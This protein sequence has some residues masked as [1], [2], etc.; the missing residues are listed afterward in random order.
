MVINRAI[1]GR[2]PKEYYQDHKVKL[3]LRSKQYHQDNKV[4][5]NLWMKQYKQTNREQISVQRKQHYQTN[6]EK[7]SLKDKQYYQEN[8][9]KIK[10]QRSKSV[11]C[12]HCSRTVQRG[13]IAR[14]Q[15]STVC[16]SHQ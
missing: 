16:K 14:H 15:K 3:N 12:P 8:K 9:E 10:E 11:T 6:K 7:M 4:K 5:M 1:A 2:T 13:S